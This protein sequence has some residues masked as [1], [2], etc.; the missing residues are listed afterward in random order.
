[1][2]RVCQCRCQKAECNQCDINIGYSIGKF[3][4][5]V[6]VIDASLIGTTTKEGDL[7]YCGVLDTD[8]GGSC[9]LLSKIDKEN[10]GRTFI[11]ELRLQNGASG[12]MV[13]KLMEYKNVHGGCEKAMSK[14]T[15][16]EQGKTFVCPFKP[17]TI[18]APYVNGSAKNDGTRR[19][20]AIKFSLSTDAFGN[21]HQ[22]VELLPGGHMW[23]NNKAQ[24]MLIDDF[25]EEYSIPGVITKKSREFIKFTEGGIVKPICIKYKDFNIMIDNVYIYLDTKDRIIPIGSWGTYGAM[26]SEVLDQLL[27]DKKF[28]MIGRAVD[29]LSKMRKFI[30]PYWCSQ[31]NIITA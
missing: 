12:A 21:S 11:P 31:P 1:M 20:Q 14:L 9:Y 18:I 23:G 19:I 2:N 25:F 5:D 16:Y 3:M 30:A 27:S 13:D 17:D 15:T 24:Y 26:K 8:K 6:K 10:K 22:R 4:Q 28:A 29:G 7:E